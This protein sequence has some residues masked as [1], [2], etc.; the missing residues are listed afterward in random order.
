[1]LALRLREGLSLSEYHRLFGCDF[2]AGKDDTVKDAVRGGY[3]TVNGD[4][5]ALT[6]SGFYI[7]NYLISSLL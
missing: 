3:L 2:L 4:R 5:V 6:E 1:M 7:S